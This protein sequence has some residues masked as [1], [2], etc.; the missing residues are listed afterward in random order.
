MNATTVGIFHTGVR[1]GG[2][3]SRAR[4]LALLSLTAVSACTL[5]ASSDVMAVS[6]IEHP[7]A[8]KCRA[9]ASV[10]LIGKV[11]RTDK[12]IRRKTGATT[13]RRIAPGDMVTQDYRP[14]RITITVDP[15]TRLVTA[16]ACG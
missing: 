15:A 16:A 5:K 14:D 10:V 1:E 12:V 3:G 6:G 13:V 8:L 7:A 2:K 4:L 9:E 11:T